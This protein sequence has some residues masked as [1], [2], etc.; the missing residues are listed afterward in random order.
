MTV[1]NLPRPQLVLSW[2]VLG[3]RHL[4]RS[5]RQPA[6]YYNED[7]VGES[8]RC[9]SV[10]PNEAAAW[11]R[12]RTVEASQSFLENDGHR[13][14]ECMSQCVDRSSKRRRKTPVQ[15]EDR[16]VVRLTSVVERESVPCLCGDPQ[17]LI[18]EVAKTAI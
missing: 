17:A 14:Y 11:Y 8:K 9:V 7:L 2:I 3:E 1:D 15:V 13:A 16:I 18:K 4:L 10:G 5:V 6:R 12:A